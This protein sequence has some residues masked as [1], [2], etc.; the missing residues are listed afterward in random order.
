MPPNLGGGDGAQRHDPGPNASFCV[1]EPCLF[2][3]FADPTE[4]DD[5]HAAHPDIVATM[6]ARLKVLVKG[7]VTLVASNLC[8]TPLGSKGDQR[9]ADS[10]KSL[11][12]WEPRLPPI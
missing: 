11:G 1:D 3:I 5:V 7:E 10:A 4:H 2:D 8:P 6:M 12:F 9:S